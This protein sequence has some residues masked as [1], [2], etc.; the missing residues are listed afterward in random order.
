MGVTFKNLNKA[1]IIGMVGDA[2]ELK[3]TGGSSHLA[4]FQVATN[5]YW[6]DKQGQKQH[7]AEWHRVVAWGKLADDVLKYIEKGTLVM[8]EGKIRNK[9]WTDK[10]GN[11]RS[12]ADIEAM[13]VIVLADAGNAKAVV[14]EAPA[15]QEEASTKIEE[16]DLPF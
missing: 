13:N 7:K 9:K 6:T 1:T 14:N 10:K 4:T 3:N 8:V 15:S 5:E 16:D 2:P 11:E 12:G